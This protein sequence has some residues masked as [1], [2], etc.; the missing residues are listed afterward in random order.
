MLPDDYDAYWAHTTSWIYW[1]LEEVSL[2]VQL[3]S[4]SHDTYVHY[5]N[6]EIELWEVKSF[7]RKVSLFS[8]MMMMIS[9]D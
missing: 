3:L 7:N 4:R 6:C 8:I 1:F 2:V 9:D 5:E